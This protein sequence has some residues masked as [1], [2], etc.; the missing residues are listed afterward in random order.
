VTVKGPKPAAIMRLRQD[1]TR[2]GEQKDDTPPR[3]NYNGRVEPLEVHSFLQ[4]HGWQKK[5]GPLTRRKRFSRKSS[6]G[7]GNRSFTF[8]RGPAG[9]L[10]VAQFA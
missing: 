2:C 4:L 7:Q 9:Q 6:Q 8:V 5:P 10:V 1:R 3:H